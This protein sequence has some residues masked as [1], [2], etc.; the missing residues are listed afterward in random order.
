MIKIININSI[1]CQY[2]CMCTYCLNYITLLSVVITFH[3]YC[4]LDYLHNDYTIFIR[5]DEHSRLQNY[6]GHTNECAV[7]TVAENTHI[8][9]GQ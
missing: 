5:R 9:S 7:V 2:N 6:K 4:I 3:Y 8:V 1:N